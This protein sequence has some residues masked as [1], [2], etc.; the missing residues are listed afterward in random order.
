MN[1]RDIN[2]KK[3]EIM[4]T[5]LLTEGGEIKKKILDQ[6]DWLHTLK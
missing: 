2:L 6:V 1:E 3:I 4:L 5:F